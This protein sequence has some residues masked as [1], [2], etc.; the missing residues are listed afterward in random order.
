MGPRRHDD[1]ACLGVILE[2][3]LGQQPDKLVTVEIGKIIKRKHPV[4]GELQHHAKAD[5]FEIPEIFGNLEAV[6]SLVDPLRLTLYEFNGPRLQ[7]FGDA[8]VKSLNG[9]QLLDWSFGNFLGKNKTLGNQQMGDHIINVERL[10]KAGRAGPELFLTALG[11]LSFC[12]DVDV[13]A[14]QL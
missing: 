10:D 12:Q 3:M 14:G 8:F 1:I 4:L 7:L 6:E 13:P 2:T 9:S 5:I 11:F